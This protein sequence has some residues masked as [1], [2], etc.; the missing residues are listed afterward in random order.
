MLKI[1]LFPL[2]RSRRF[3]R[4]V[5]D[6][7]GD[8]FHFVADAGRDP[9]EK[10]IRDPGD[11]GCH[12]VIGRDCPQSHRIAIGPGIA[13]DTDSSGISQYRKILAGLFFKISFLKFRCEDRI[14]I[15]QDSELFFC[16]LT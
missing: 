12:E 16:D 6:D 9:F 10:L 11:P 7:T 13:L 4:D 15:F 5:I 2:D 14:G 1:S 3:G 8:I